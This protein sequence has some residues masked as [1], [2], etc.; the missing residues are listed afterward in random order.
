[1][2]VL[3]NAKIYTLWDAKPTATAVAIDNGKI[4]AAGSDDDVLALAPRSSKRTDLNGKAVW[5]GLTD[6]HIH[7]Q[8]FALGLNHIDCDTTTRDECLKRVSDTAARTSQGSWVRGHGWNQNDWPEGFGSAAL[9]DESAPGQP[10]YLTAKSLHAGWANT[11]ALRL[12]GISAAT[13]DPKDGVIQRDPTGS[14]TGILFESAMKLIEDAIPEPSQNEITRAVGQAQAVLWSLGLTGVHDFDRRSCFQAL[15]T[16]DRAGELKMRVVKSIPLENLADA[17]AVGLQTGF[18]SDFLRIGSVKLFADGALGPQTAAML[19]PYDN[20]QDNYGLL[21]LDAE[22]IL[23]YGQLAAKSGL[24]LAVHAIGDRANHEVLKA[25]AQLRQF[26]SKENLP[27]LKHRIEHVQVLHPEHISLLASLEIV[28]SMQPVHTTSDMDTAD[29][30]WG[31]RARYAYALKS[32]RD[33][34]TR[35][36]FGSDAPVESPNPFWGLHAAVTRRR[37][38][39]YPSENGWNPQERLGLTQALEGYTVNPAD[40]AGWGKTVGRLAP[41]CHADLIVLPDDPF[42]I[43]PSSLYQIRPEWVMVAGEWVFGG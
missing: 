16:L 28:A 11:A 21:F 35:L 14:P 27:H 39:G 24:S 17:V 25:Y 29:R 18:G 9:L 37:H 13:P 7:L 31:E 1:M 38:T 32:L 19:Q 6:S 42:Q 26:E 8:H 15:Q 5:P 22:Q 34:G 20:G 33:C 10:V 30:Y 3:H 41:G 43:D 2:H 4:I 40:V 36:I 23:E 12:A